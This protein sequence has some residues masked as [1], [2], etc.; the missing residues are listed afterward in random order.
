MNTD[1]LITFKEYST[2]K[3]E[4]PYFYSV[5]SANQVLYYFGAEH[6]KDPEHPQFELLNVKWQDFLTKTRGGK[7]VVF[8]EE[9]VN[10]KNLTSL[11]QAI[12]QHGE[13][14]AIVYWANKEHV[15]CVR[16]EPTIKDEVEELLKNFSADEI[17][18]FYIMRGI[19]SWQRTALRKEFNE[20][21]ET[22][23][24]RYREDLS[25]EN[26]DFSFETVKRTHR[27]IF[28]KEL[29][30]AD[31]AF[32]AKIPNPI[33]DES[34]I[35]NIAR[36]SSTIRNITILHNIENYWQ[37]GYNV[38]VVYGASHAVMQERALKHVEKF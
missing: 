12:E 31:T 14:G 28:G 8:Y 36:A 9:K 24:K 22:N 4:R 37:E 25:W 10:E 11:S 5:T 18:Y 27:Y 3:H 26:F 1:L 7:A 38:F 32:I 21:I 15:P 34:N 23:I 17:F 6:K 13:S 30:L 20:F 35:N 19:A 2:I 29:D 33:Y 16:P